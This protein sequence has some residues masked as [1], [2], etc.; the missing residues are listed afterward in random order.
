MGAVDIAALLGSVTTAASRLGEL[1]A[2]LVKSVSAA[3][4][5][6]LDAAASGEG[7]GIH[8]R[9][10]TSEGLDGALEVTATDVIST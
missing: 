1:E 9:F 2:A 3:R 7:Q 5:G 10:P 8:C 4:N 6:P